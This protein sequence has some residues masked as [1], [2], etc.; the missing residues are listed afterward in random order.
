MQ[1]QYIIDSC[2]FFFCNFWREPASENLLT[3]VWKGQVVPPIIKTQRLWAAISSLVFNKSLLNLAILLILRRS[4][5]WCR[6][7]FPLFVHVKVEMN[8][9]R[10]YCLGSNIKF[11]VKLWSLKMIISFWWG[12]DVP[13]FIVGKDTFSK[14]MSV[15]FALLKSCC[16]LS[17]CSLLFLHDVV[18]LFIY[19]KFP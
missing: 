6:P 3:F 11:I 12:G 13:W 17:N 1:H 4:F 5:Q 15:N 19:Q 2:T 9:E 7:I 14:P 10:V 8:R 18:K 16:M